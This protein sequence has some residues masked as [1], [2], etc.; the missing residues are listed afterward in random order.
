MP[1]TKIWLAGYKPDWLYGIGYVPVSVPYGGKYRKTSNN[2]LTAVQD[3]RISDDFILFNDDFFV[4]KPTTDFQTLHRGPLIDHLNR[5]KAERPKVSNP[6]YHGIKRTYDILRRMGFDEPLNYGLHTPMIMNRVKWL[7][8]WEKQLEFNPKGLPIHLRTFYGNMH[9][10]GGEQID[11]V[12]LSQF[13]Q[14]PTGKE[15]FLSSNDNSFTIG[16]IGV[17]IRSNFPEAC[18]Y[19]YADP[20]MFV[21]K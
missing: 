1:G 7:E 11:D 8:M 20:K 15:I 3:P 4:M 5:L 10:I 9:Q 12:K 18:K 17:Y 6:Y 13:D 19:E 21:L 2:I 14:K 16:E